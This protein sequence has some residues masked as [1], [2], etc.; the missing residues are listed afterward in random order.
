MATI[1]QARLVAALAFARFGFAQ[2]WVT[3]VVADGIY[4]QGYTPLLESQDTVPET[5]GWSVPDN[6][7]QA[8][9]LPAKYQDR[10]VI[11][12]VGAMPAQKSAL[13]SAG[14]KLNIQ[15]TQWP[16]EHQ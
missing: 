9:I 1:W 6:L 5:V 12:N 10:D 3:G 2:G 7:D 13:V 14:G 4:Y 15:W 16:K 11:C 8:P